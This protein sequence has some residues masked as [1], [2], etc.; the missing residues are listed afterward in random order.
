MRRKGVK[1]DERCFKRIKS[2]GY[3]ILIQTDSYLNKFIFWRV[4]LL[5][6]GA[7]FH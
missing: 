6:I 7:P 4:F 2:H 5:G 1:G 3:P